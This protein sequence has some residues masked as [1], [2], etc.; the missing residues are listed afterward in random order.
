MQSCLRS[1]SDTSVLRADENHTSNVAY[2]IAQNLLVFLSLPWKLGAG[3]ELIFGVPL[4]L[5]CVLMFS[6]NRGFDHLFALFVSILLENCT[7]STEAVLY[8]HSTKTSEDCLMCTN[9][10]PIGAPTATFSLGSMQ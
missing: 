6:V 8:I 3:K 4:S 1:A 10:S 7:L 5:Y 2:C 9:H